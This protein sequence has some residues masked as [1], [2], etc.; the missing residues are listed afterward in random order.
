[1]HGSWQDAMA[2]TQRACE[3]LAQP[4]V[5]LALGMA[6]YQRGE[7]HR[8]RGEDDEAEAAYRAAN[9]YGHDPQPG[10]ALLRLAR[11]Q[12]ESATAAIKRALGEPQRPTRRL[13]LLAAQVE[14]AI[15]AGDLSTAHSAAEELSASAATRTAPLLTAAALHATGAVLLAAGEPHDALPVL[16]RAWSAWQD[17]AAPYDAA[18]SR[19]LVGLACRALGDDDTAEME[20]DAARWVFDQLGA[21]RDAAHVAKLSRRTPAVRVPG[22]LTLREVQVLRLVATGATNRSIAADLFLSE[23]T[24]ARHIANIFT[25]LGISSRAAATAYAY[26]HRLV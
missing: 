24:V 16:R 23:K 2:D 8:L 3:R 17:I 6:L 15:A 18:R 26:E 4:P 21:A 5:Q 19:L 9:Q 10:L 20:L 11:G 1:L 7:L 22:G 13:S 12:V 25:K 14:I